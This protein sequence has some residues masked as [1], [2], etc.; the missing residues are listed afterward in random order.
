MIENERKRKWRN[1]TAWECIKGAYFLFI[2][3]CID[4]I[5]NRDE[6]AKMEFIMAKMTIAGRFQVSEDDEE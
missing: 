6:A 3:G 5:L 4:W 1:P 2:G